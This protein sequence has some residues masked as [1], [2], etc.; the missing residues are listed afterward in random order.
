MCVGHIHSYG[1]G[2]RQEQTHLH[3]KGVAK[4][5]FWVKWPPLKT[6]TCPMP[7]KA[8]SFGNGVFVDVTELK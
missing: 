5:L 1:K 4:V 8:T 3:Y 7:L 2:L 6:H